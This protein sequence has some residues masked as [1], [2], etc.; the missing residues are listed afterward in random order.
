M[1]LQRF[2]DADRL[3]PA[4]RI[5]RRRQIAAEMARVAKASEQDCQ[6]AD[7]RQVID[8]HGLLA[9]EQVVMASA[10]TAWEWVR[11]GLPRFLAGL[12]LGAIT[13]AVVHACT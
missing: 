10:W 11:W 3:L 8:L 7:R 12:A 1:I 5:E 2:H 4:E 9:S 6:P 13:V